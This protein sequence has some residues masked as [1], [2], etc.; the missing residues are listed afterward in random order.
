MLEAFQRHLFRHWQVS[1]LSLGKGQKDRYVPIGIR[2]NI[3]HRMASLT[4]LAKSFRG[5]ANIGH[6][7]LRL[8]DRRY[9]SDN[10]VY[11]LHLQ[12]LITRLND[13]FRERKQSAIWPS[14]FD[15]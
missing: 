5:H 10:A 9:R 15:Y 6:P 13:C 2:P 12:P 1:F 14:T 3:T 8:D 4:A 7:F 11:R